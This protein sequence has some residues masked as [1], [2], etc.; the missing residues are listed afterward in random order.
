MP[1]AQNL[2]GQKF[3]KLTALAP[4]S[5][6]TRNGSRVWACTCDCGGIAEVSQQALKSGHTKS[7][8]CGRLT[9]TTGS[10]QRVVQALGHWSAVPKSITDIME[11]TKLSWLTV[12]NA[13]RKLHSSEYVYIPEWENASTPLWSLRDPNGPDDLMIDAP[14]PKPKTPGQRVSDH[15]R[16]RK[17][18]EAASAVPVQVEIETA[19]AAPAQN[20]VPEPAAPAWWESLKD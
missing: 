11:L 17:D 20:D 3:G 7:C 1:K 9:R 4:L 13:L 6:R 12:R 14:R 18:A 16:K 5:K 15:R 8:G 2:A 10:A 19:T